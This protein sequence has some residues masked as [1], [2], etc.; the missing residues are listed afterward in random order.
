MTRSFLL[1]ICR[2]QRS[3]RRFSYYFSV[4]VNPIK[5]RCPTTAR[6]TRRP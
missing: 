4:H 5:E 1:P 3:G 2:P 6:Q